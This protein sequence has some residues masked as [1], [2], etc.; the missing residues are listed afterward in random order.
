M[1]KKAGKLQFLLLAIG[2]LLTWFIGY[3]A[4]Q[5]LCNISLFLFYHVS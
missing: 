3:Y 1:Q 4:P 2:A 5:T